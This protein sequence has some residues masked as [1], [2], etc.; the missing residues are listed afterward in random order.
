MRKIVIGALAAALITYAPFAADAAPPR[1]M[2]ACTLVGAQDVFR[3]LGWTIQSHVR[4][5][6]SVLGAMGSM[7]FLESPQGEVIVTVPDRGADFIGATP[8][9]DSS[10][11]SLSRHVYGLGGD[12]TLYNGTAY[13]TRYKRSVAVRVVPN[14]NPASYDDVEGFASVIIAHM[15]AL[16]PKKASRP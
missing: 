12:V 11:A 9:N 2:D 8:Y 7:C 1:A 6:Y 13:V 16:D 10:A 14:E 3:V 5:P 15:R 4:R